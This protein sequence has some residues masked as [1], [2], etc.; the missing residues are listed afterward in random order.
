MLDHQRVPA[1]MRQSS[2]AGEIVSAPA[3][4]VVTLGYRRGPVL[5]FG[6]IPLTSGVAATRR[7]DQTPTAGNRL[8]RLIRN[9]QGSSKGQC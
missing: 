4:L 6:D 7:S 2:P 1:T 9:Q 3:R 8:I 5:T